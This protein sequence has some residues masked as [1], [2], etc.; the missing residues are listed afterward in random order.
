[1][2]TQVR[3]WQRTLFV[4]RVDEIAGEIDEEELQSN[5][6]NK[7]EGERGRK[8][9]SLWTFLWHKKRSSERENG[10]RVRSLGVGGR[11]RMIE[12]SHRPEVSVCCEKTRTDRKTAN[13]KERVGRC[14][15]ML[16]NAGEAKQNDKKKQK[17]V[18]EKVPKSESTQTCKKHETG[19]TIRKKITKTRQANLLIPSDWFE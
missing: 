4:V 19:K 3:M 17:I 6:S 8:K 5:Q 14:I 7:G 1:L 2:V 13:E 10:G 16:R 12:N 15:E 18:L 9:Q 11:T